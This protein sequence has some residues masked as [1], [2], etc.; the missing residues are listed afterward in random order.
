MNNTPFKSIRLGRPILHI[1]IC[2][3]YQEKYQPHYNEYP[4]YNEWIVRSQKIRY[5]GIPLY[6]C[7]KV[8]NCRQRCLFFTAGKTIAIE[9]DSKLL[10]RI[11]VEWH[12]KK[13]ISI[14]ELWKISDHVCIQCICMVFMKPDIAI[15]Q[16]FK[17]C[18]TH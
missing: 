18:N 1:S 3:E 14:F 5:N 9:L 4:K 16:S 6:T 12:L 11:I 13:C 10:Q 2:Y 17:G 15:Q 8:W 7:N